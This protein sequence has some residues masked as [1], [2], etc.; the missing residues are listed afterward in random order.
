MGTARVM[1][2]GF[3]G[4]SAHVAV[5]QLARA[6]RQQHPLIDLEFLPGRY[7]ASVLSDLLRHGK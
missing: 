4:P 7:G 5:G 2:I 3:G 6:V 1:Q